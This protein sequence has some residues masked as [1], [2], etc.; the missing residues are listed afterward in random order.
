MTDDQLPTDEDRRLLRDSIRNFLE[1]HWP[2]SDAVKR[3]DD[4][5]EIQAIARRLAEQ[6]LASLGSDPSEGGLQEILILQEE[7]GRAACPVPLLASS[8]ASI[9]LRSCGLNDTV[10]SELL[11]MLRE[12]KALAALAFG[13]L[14]G[15][16]TAGMV[17][18][19]DD[20]ISGEAR[21][22]DM[23]HCATHFI[24][25]TSPTSI[26]VIDARAK[27]VNVTAT[28]V[29]G[30]HG[31]AKARFSQAGVLTTTHV[32]AQ[33]LED[34]V[35]IERLALTARALGAADRAFELVVQYAK[36]RKQFGK[37][38]GQFQG[39]Q[40]K[41][42][43]NYIGLLG[44]RQSLA[45]AGSSYDRGI[46]E[47]K[48]F[49]ASVC[50]VASNVLRQASLETHHAFGAIGYT[51]EHEAPRH[52]KRVH[53]DV[54]RH[55]GSRRGREELAVY[56]LDHSNQLPQYDLGSG[57]NAFREEVRGWLKVH[58]TKERQQQMLSRPNAHREYD[59]EFARELG[60]TGWIGLNW[61]KKFGGQ[62]RSPMEYLA[63]VE[64]L[65]RHEAPRAGAPIQAVSW[66]LFGT[67]AQ[68]K[69]YLPEILRG[70]AV[71]GMWYSEPDSGSDLVSMR[72]R[73]V[74]DGDEWVIN[75]QKIWTTSFWGDYMWLAAKTDLDAKPAHAGI[76]MFCVPTGTKG[77]T[78]RPVKT[79]YDGEF[80]NTFLDD[81]R[82]P[83]ECLVGE[84]NGGWE[85]LTGSLGTERGVV[86]ATILAKLAHAFDLVCDFIRKCEVSGQPLRKDPIVRDTIGSFAAQIEIGRQL[87]LHCAVLAGT[88][89]TPPHIAAITK[90]YASELMERFFE[91]VQEL[92]GMEAALSLGSEDTI[93]RGRLEQKLRHSLMWVISLGTN[94]IQRNL[95]AT[96]GLGLPR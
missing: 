70:E 39:I 78:I 24:L 86:G 50:A 29:L 53:Q 94:E 55:G 21:Y 11:S 91:S 8:L 34:L 17:S 16:R 7:L 18:L 47:W 66:M 30:A 49:A 31:L 43:N 10:I 62:G 27:G 13:S 84:V 64:E 15:D 20:Y 83:A 87:A 81:V 68:Q 76:S 95:I 1:V 74:R 51:E 45:N 32:E 42:V 59:P 85:V 25:V 57:A 80:I 72:T 5:K 54:L 79:M 33:E 82:I 23:A 44:L 67:E 22:L 12:G 9:L 56:L 75:G 90:V 4:P 35:R 63:F 2:A 71:Y 93:L 92:L 89:E 38:I 41:L 26:A 37:F 46:A 19:K 6:G 36:E 77:V 60:K 69:R 61:P 52:F 28:R 88:G 65:E 96:R 3:A 73:A 58:W 48:V 40:H 14:D